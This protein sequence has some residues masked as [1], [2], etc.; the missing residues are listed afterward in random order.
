MRQ[1]TPSFYFIKELYRTSPDASA[2]ITG[3]TD[4]PSLTGTVSFYQSPYTG[5]LIQAE[6]RGLPSGSNT[7]SSE[8]NESSFFA[9][10]IH[11]YG[12]C[13]P[14]FDKTGMHYNPQNTLH[15]M[16]AG[17][18]VPLLGNHG[19]AWCVFYDE[20]FTLPEIIGRS[21]IIHRNPD[22]F[23]TQPS[24]NSGEKIGCGTIRWVE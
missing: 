11:E 10:H 12:D 23:H 17:D 6:I 19:Y 21:V 20:R 15:P 3:N 7:P 13:T 4:Y 5:L 8:N 22:D 18:L 1:I 2:H 24:G 16:H 9:M 14:P